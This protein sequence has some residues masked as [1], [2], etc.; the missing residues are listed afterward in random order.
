MAGIWPVY[1]TYGGGFDTA[2]SDLKGSCFCGCRVGQFSV[3]VGLDAVSPRET[4]A[5]N[6]TAWTRH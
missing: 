4:L 2:D 1:L 5:H 6:A 3:A